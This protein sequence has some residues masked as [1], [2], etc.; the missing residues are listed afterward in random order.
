[1]ENCI[2]ARRIASRHPNTREFTSRVVARLLLLRDFK[3]G[4]KAAV[5]FHFESCTRY[6]ILCIGRG[7]GGA[8]KGAT[9]IQGG[10]GGAGG[11]GE[12][13]ARI[14]SKAIH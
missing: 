4:F 14:S 11:G 2:A 8:R 5:I 7:A 12:E 9:S 13:R 6:N 10:G 3:R 1:M